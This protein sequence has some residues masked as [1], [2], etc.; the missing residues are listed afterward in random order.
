PT[1]SCEVQFFGNVREG[2]ITV[3]VIE[4]RYTKIP[5]KKI[6][7]AI[8]IVI[9]YGD[10]HPPTLVRDSGLGRSIFELETPE[11]S[12]KRRTRCSFL[13]LD[14]RQCRS[15]HQINIEHPIAVVIEDCN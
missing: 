3:I 2:P 8:V 13:T 12:I 9:A 7:P 4:P 11:V 14:R 15:I 6:R 5:Y 10:A 1:L